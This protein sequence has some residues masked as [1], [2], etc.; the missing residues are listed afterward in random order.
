MRITN[1]RFLHEEIDQK[2][3]TNVSL[4]IMRLDSYKIEENQK[5]NIY[6][7]LSSDQDIQEEFGGSNEKGL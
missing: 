7:W 4:I 6:K 2:I 3:Y 1:R 5:L